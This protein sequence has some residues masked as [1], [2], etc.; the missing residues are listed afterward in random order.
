MF[1]VKDKYRNLCKQKNSA[2]EVGALLDSYGPALI[3]HY[4]GFDIAESLELF[5]VLMET[6]PLQERAQILFSRQ[7]QTETG[8]NVLHRAC[9][10]GDSSL[11]GYWLSSGYFTGEKLITRDVFGH[12]PLHLAATCDVFKRVID[13]IRQDTELTVADC[14]EPSVLHRACYKAHTQIIHYIFTEFPADITLRLVF[15]AD[16]SGLTAFHHAANSEVFCMLLNFVVS[17]EKNG[18]GV[19]LDAVFVGGVLRRA[20]ELDRADI[21][22]DIIHHGGPSKSTDIILNRDSD[23]RTALHY[24]ATASIAKMIV[25]NVNTAEQHKLLLPDRDGLT[26]LHRAAAHQSAGVVQ[27]MID[28]SCGF[29]AYND[30][31]SL[32]DKYGCTPLH[33]ANTGDIAACFLDPLPPESQE[34][35]ITSL[36]NQ[37]ASPLHH[38]CEMG[39]RPDVVE[40]LLRY[41]SMFNV[42]VKMFIL[43]P[44]CKGVTS[45][46]EACQNRETVVLQ[47]LLQIGEELNILPELI[48]CASEGEFSLL[49]IAGSIEVARYLMGL[50]ISDDDKFKLLTHS[51]CIER[52]NAFHSAAFYRR[53]WLARYILFEIPSYLI[54]GEVLKEM[55]GYT[56]FYGD[57]PFLLAVKHGNCD[58]IKTML[59]Y[60]SSSSEN[61]NILEAV[62]DN[63]DHQLKNA[64]HIAALH[65]QCTS[66]MVAL[67]RYSHLV[68]QKILFASFDIFRN[69]P[70]NYLAGR[71]QAK[72]FATFFHAL[73]MH[74]RKHI[75]CQ[76]NVSGANCVDILS[77]KQFE[78]EIYHS[79]VMCG[80]KNI[81]FVK[82][83]RGGGRATE[84][85][86]HITPSIIYKAQEF[87]NVSYDDRLW[88]VIRYGLNQYDI[89]FS[90]TLTD[91]TYA[92]RKV[93][94]LTRTHKCSSDA[95]NELHQETVSFTILLMSAAL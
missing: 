36:D 41:I 11:V 82:G 80:N 52:M 78:P 9:R 30:W 6:I 93:A 76:R 33:Y 63:R 16:G 50:L 37:G 95:K 7:S 90:V 59:D 43:S 53:E 69:S 3:R 26:A 83:S 72:L 68:H 12:T 60:L 45:L 32:A 92:G 15:E 22:P 67:L 10:D 48:L 17:H 14:L 55:L 61:L 39:G 51:N 27:S 88:T 13:A 20:C 94:C 66:L 75:L 70:M 40:T 25:S 87:V 18:I 73:P 64:F 47:H 85:E 84:L 56:N 23:G 58:F 34:K 74:L 21:V 81:R 77:Q 71:Y 49:Q 46:Q 5:D 2:S 65:P 62:F 19:K 57:T 8:E 89:T 35:I 24:V 28:F 31:V 29:Q 42:D 44:N 38:A 54:P 1:G 86:I 79:V 91:P 4:G